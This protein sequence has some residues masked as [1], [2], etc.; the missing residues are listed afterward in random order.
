VGISTVQRPG[1]SDLGVQVGADAADLALADA[2]V[3]SQHPDQGHRALCPFR[4]HYLRG[5]ADHRRGRSKVVTH[6][7]TGGYLHHLTG[8]DWRRRNRRLVPAEVS[9]VRC[10][11]HSVTMLPVAAY[12][13]SPEQRS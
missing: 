11:A 3:G 10:T 4:E 12:R 2:A 13:Q 1:T 8:Q 9:T 6:D 5:L 7:V